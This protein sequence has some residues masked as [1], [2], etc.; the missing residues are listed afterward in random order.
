[1]DQFSGVGQL[2]MRPKLWLNSQSQTV[3][4]RLTWHTRGVFAGLT[5][6][7]AVVEQ[8]TDANCGD[9]CQ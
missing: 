8:D 7:G 4:F 2:R 1:M 6:E 5:L 3:P 9:L